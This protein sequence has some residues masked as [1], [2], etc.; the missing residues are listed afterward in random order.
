MA[1]LHVYELEKHPTI[2]DFYRQRVK[3]VEKEFGSEPYIQHILGSKSSVE[4]MRVHLLQQMKENT[5]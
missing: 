3:R 4:W 5:K 2:S 1:I